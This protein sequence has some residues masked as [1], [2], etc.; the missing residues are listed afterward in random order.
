MEEKRE[1][2]KNEGIFFQSCLDGGKWKEMKTNRGKNKRQNC[3][4]FV[5][6]IE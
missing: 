3:S 5:S 2:K 4:N 1:K 6:K